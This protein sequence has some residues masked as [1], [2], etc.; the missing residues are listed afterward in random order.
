MSSLKSV[1]E[2]RSEERSEEGL[3]VGA[4]VARKTEGPG[5]RKRRCGGRRA[6]F[7]H[8]VGPNPTQPPPDL[9]RAGYTNGI[10]TRPFPF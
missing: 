6:R 1:S 8:V 2:E 3:V 10:R 4:K 5:N 7:V 9:L